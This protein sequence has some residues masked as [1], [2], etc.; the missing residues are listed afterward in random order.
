MKEAAR[1]EARRLRAEDGWSIKR[2]AREVHA[3]QSTVSLWV[4][5]VD[6]T[7]EQRRAL[8]DWTETARRNGNARTTARARE[9]RR[10]A[11]ADGRGRAADRNALHL[12]GCMLYWAEGG[13]NRN[14][15]HFT[16]SDP[17]MVVMFVRFLRECYGAA[18]DQ[19]RLTCNCFTNN[20]ITLEAIEAWW[21][22]RLGLDR[23][24]LCRSVVNTPSR[25]SK[26]KH[27]VLLYGTV[28]VTIYSTAIVQ[29]IYGAIQEYAGIERPEW[30]DGPPRRDAPPGARTQTA[31][32]KDRNSAS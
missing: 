5:D 11:Q 18:N 25:A 24:S 21:L 8:R 12:A 15:V 9:V 27:K 23:E 4:R 31:G 16:N 3:A 7:P 20:G 26:G 28:R 6:L 14:C 10:A 19:I 2:I 30:L 17:D 22:A 1:E 29:S 32:L 13:K